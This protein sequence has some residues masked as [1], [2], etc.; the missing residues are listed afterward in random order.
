MK[1]K[2]FF[3][4]VLLAALFL[5]VVGTLISCNEDGVANSKPVVVT[6]IFPPYDFAR[7][8]GGDRIDLS[9]LVTVTDSHSF[10][11][12]AADMAMIEECDL[13][14]YTGGDGD[15]WA[16]DFLNTI[17]TKDKVILNLME[18][19][20]LLEEGHDH[21]HD[22]AHEHEHDYSHDHEEKGAVYDEHVWLDPENAVT[23][24]AAIREA[25]I[26]IDPAGERIYQSAAEE[27]ITDLQAL[28]REF[29]QMVENAARREIVVADRFPFLYLCEA[30]G[31]SYEAAIDG[32]GSA[33][34]LT[35]IAYE[36]LADHVREQDLPIILCA[37]YSDQT[38]ANTV[39]RECNRHAEILTLH[40]CHTL[41]K[42]AIRE[43]VT[44]LSL[45]TENLR[46][47]TLALN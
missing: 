12:T 47:L 32:C 21:E 43:G 4:I 45:M 5:L 3:A 38:I 33:S 7:A 46:I 10:S 29:S 26:S 37:E 34:D 11:P 23:I 28:D 1:L 9:V 24:T 16:E 31:I 40:S 36:E 6:T 42:G 22:H 27:Y 2:R 30:Y 20:P 18:L 39:L 14:I 44:Y 17:E 15:L 41:T 13:F 35:A 25:L 19:C 8:V